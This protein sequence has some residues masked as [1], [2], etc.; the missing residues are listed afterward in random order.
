MPLQVLEYESKTLK[1]VCYD[2]YILALE[3]ARAHKLETGKST[4]VIC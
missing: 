1:L 4:L 3:L 2:T